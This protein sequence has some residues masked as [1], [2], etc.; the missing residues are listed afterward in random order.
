M[1]EPFLLKTTKSHTKSTKRSMCSKVAH[2][3]TSTLSKIFRNAFK[4]LQR[5]LQDFE[6]KVSFKILE[7]Y[8][9]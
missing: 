5:L 8:I 9:G 3:S 7:R 2:V 6:S 4:I 1:G